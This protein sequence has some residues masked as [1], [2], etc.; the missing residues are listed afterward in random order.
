M[1]KF[2]LVDPSSPLPIYKQPKGNPE[3]LPRNIFGHC[4]KIMCTTEN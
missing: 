4:I 3:K 2:P 1:V